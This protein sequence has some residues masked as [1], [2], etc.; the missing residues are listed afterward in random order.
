MTRRG[1]HLHA[2]KG[3][4]VMGMVGGGAH[5]GA[6]PL[7]HWAPEGSKFGTAAPLPTPICFELDDIIDQRHAGTQR[8]RELRQ[9]YKRARRGRRR[10][11]RAPTSG[12]RPVRRGA[13]A[14]GGAPFVLVGSCVAARYARQVRAV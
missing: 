10:G 11:C 3:Q 14:G 7:A 4:L 1:E 12:A 8:L 13:T 9:A 2:R 6:V 5:D